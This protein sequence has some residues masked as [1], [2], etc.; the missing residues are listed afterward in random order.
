[1]EARP[2][3]S[4]SCYGSVVSIKYFL[5]ELCKISP[6]ANCIG[7]FRFN[8]TELHGSVGEPISAKVLVGDW[9]GCTQFQLLILFAF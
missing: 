4:F 8:L 7:D 2:Q 6:A 5:I 9:G 3:K 1:M